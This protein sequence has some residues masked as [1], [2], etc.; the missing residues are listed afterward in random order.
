MI[1]VKILFIYSTIVILCVGLL[2][3]GTIT[4]IDLHDSY[5]VIDNIHISILL[6][7][8]T[9]LTALLYHA[10]EKIDRPIRHRSGLWH[11]GL[12]AAGLIILFITPYAFSRT[13]FVNEIGW[14]SKSLVVGVV[15]ALGIILFLVSLPVF[16]YGAVRALLNKKSSQFK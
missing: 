11:F 12:F 5:F 7:V 10:L 1:S 13:T 8:L 14:I 15:Y 9:S 2:V 4:A 6:A 16:A 3:R